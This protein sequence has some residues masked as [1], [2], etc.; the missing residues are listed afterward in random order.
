MVNKGTIPEKFKAIYGT[1]EFI[2]VFTIALL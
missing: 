1:R 2:A